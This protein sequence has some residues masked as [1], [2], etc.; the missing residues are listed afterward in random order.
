MKKFIALAAFVAFSISLNAQTKLKFGWINSGELLE[1]MPEKKKAGVT[2]DSMA[3]A[4]ENILRFLNDE[5]EKKKKD[6]MAK[7]ATMDPEQRKR[8]EEELAK[9]EDALYVQMQ[10][11]QEKVSK[12]EKELIDPIL[13][14]I[15]KAIKEVG[16][17]NGYTYIFDI[18]L[19]QVLV[20]PEGDNV[21]KLVKKKLG[22][23]VME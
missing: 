2:V 16:T 5:Y 21:L 7:A 17:E 9:I 18:S 19:Q 11:S 20:Y 10:T 8:A 1:V 6:Y 3:K 22:I 12:A 15:F 14:K 4:E 13:D 23:P